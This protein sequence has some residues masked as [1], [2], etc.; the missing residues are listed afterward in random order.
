M[1]YYTEWRDLEKEP[2][3]DLDLLNRA[4]WEPRAVNYD[5]YRSLLWVDGHDKDAAN[6]PVMIGRY[7]EANIVDFLNSGS[8]LEKAN[9]IAFSQEL[10]RNN[11]TNSD[12]LAE[13][14]VQ[15]Q[16]PYAPLVVPGNFSQMV[17]YDGKTVTG[18]KMSRDDTYLIEAVDG[19]FGDVTETLPY[20]GLL[21]PIND[22]DGVSEIG[23]IYDEV[24][25]DESPNA[26]RVMA[27]G[28]T[29]IDQNIALVGVDWRH[30]NNIELATR[31][32]LDYI[33]T[34]NGTVVPIEL[35]SF[36]ATKSGNRVDL[37]WITASE[38]G[39]SR[40][41]VEKAVRTVSGDSPFE[42]VATLGAAGYSEE[43]R[44]YGPIHDSKVS[45]GNTYVYRLKM[46]DADGTFDYSD[47]R[48]VEFGS[49]SGLSIASI[50]PSP[51]VATST[52][53]YSIGSESNVTI[54][55]YDIT[56]KVVVTYDKGTQAAG[57]YTQEINSM[58]M[59]SGTYTV[60]LTS[61][62]DIKT[63]QFTVVK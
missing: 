40:F 43:A 23:M 57:S 15:A 56:G 60:V 5:H 37:T 54:E 48:V 51:V 44:N 1:G 24:M 26:L 19:A 27:V 46:V 13:L 22:G 29:T 2:Q 39:S 21:R 45:S 38:R 59:V 14:K 11:R 47:E 49:T 52:M 18:V 3:Y 50:T 42:T 35:L 25:N 6:N 16:V 4:G 62:N 7:Q 30:F 10:V 20:P 8:N 41:D 28:A 55:I 63:T 32:V 58:N 36:D 12:F 17:S 61:G 34:N 31:G 53:S 33:K 9:F